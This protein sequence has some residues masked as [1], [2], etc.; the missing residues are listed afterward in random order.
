MSNIA[1]KIAKILA[2]AD[3]TTNPEEADTFMAKAQQL[4]MEHGLS[5]LDIGKLDSD[6]PIGTTEQAASFF[7]AENWAK[8]VGGQLARF[9][10]CEVMIE[11]VGRNKYAFGLAGRESARTTFMLMF[12]F[13]LKQVRRLA[14][15][16]TKAGNFETEARAKTAIGN[17]LGLRIY[18]MIQE[19][20]DSRRED[21][22]GR[23]MNAVVA[24]DL[25]RQAL[26][27]H[28]PNLRTSRRRS[29]KTNSAGRAAAGKVS[30]HRQT[31]AA[32]AARQIGR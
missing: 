3:S 23:G 2:K 22:P 1:D 26:E 31:G 18:R 9:Y 32:P 11:Q 15:E 20:E 21:L 16:E 25:N 14:R 7:A 4:M 24:V 30:L 6:D 27:E 28:W 8:L 19:Q 17:A 10:G 29:V 5:L 13:V 12:P